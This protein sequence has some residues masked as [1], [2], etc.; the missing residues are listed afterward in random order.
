MKFSI[1]VCLMKITCQGHNK[2]KLR[3]VLICYA[4]VSGIAKQKS[5]YSNNLANNIIIK[6]MKYEQPI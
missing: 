1:W 2:S 3:Y 4:N 5:E 6:L